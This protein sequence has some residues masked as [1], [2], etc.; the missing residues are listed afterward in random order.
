MQSGDLILDL[1]S[2]GQDFWETGRVLARVGQS[3]KKI[4]GLWIIQI[5][6]NYR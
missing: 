4:L 1:G 3:R 6:I 2:N 5:K